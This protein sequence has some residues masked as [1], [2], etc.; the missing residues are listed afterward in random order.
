MSVALSYVQAMPKLN[1]EGDYL[2]GVASRFFGEG[3]A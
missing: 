3:E 1:L 2:D